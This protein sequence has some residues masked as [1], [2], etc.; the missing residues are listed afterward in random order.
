[1]AVD[2][3]T[4]KQDE[5]ELYQIDDKAILPFFES[6]VD[7]LRK[8]IQDRRCQNLSLLEYLK[9]F[10]R[11]Y[12]LPFNMQRYMSVQT[13]YIKQVLQERVQDRQ[14]AVSHWIQEHAGRHRNRMIQ[15]QCLYLD[16]I[17]DSLLPEI[18]KLLERRLET[19]H[20]KLDENK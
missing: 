9:Q 5:L 10:I 12:K 4:K 8:F 20:S 13:T 11:T 7:E 17:K 2:E 1:M 19:L 3:A 15:L 14:G 18:Q 16:R 6:H